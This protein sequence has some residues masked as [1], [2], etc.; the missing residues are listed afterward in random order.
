[1][2][3]KDIDAHYEWFKNKNIEELNHLFVCLESCINHTLVVLFRDDHKNILCVKILRVLQNPKQL[4]CNLQH[5]CNWVSEPKIVFQFNLLVFALEWNLCILKNTLNDSVEY[6][7]S[8]TTKTLLTCREECSN[9][10]C[11]TLEKCYIY[12]AKWQQ[13]VR[14]FI[15]QLHYTPNRYFS[16][17]ATI[18]C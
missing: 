8:H 16:V 1:M 9:Q 17:Q 2:S 14:Y 12:N 10:M 18:N 7:E 11:T 13:I 6:I 4:L 15:R 5:Q 3:I